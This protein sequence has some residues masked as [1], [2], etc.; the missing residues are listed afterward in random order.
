MMKHTYTKERR[1]ALESIGLLARRAPLSLAQ[2]ERLERA[3]RV[4]RTDS[5]WVTERGK[6]KICVAIGE[7]AAVTLEAVADRVASSPNRPSLS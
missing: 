5:N 7:V 1:R 6:R 2:R 3:S 4:L